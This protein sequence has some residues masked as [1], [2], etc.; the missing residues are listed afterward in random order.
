MARKQVDENSSFFQHT[1]T[2]CSVPGPVTFGDPT[3]NMT[4]HQLCHFG[5]KSLEKGENELTGVR[6]GVM[7]ALGNCRELKGELPGV[8][9]GGCPGRLPGKSG[10]GGQ[11]LLEELAK[12]EMG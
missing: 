6:L 3:L 1:F 12:R 7:S 9:V 5:L 8:R 4:R 11:E 2:E 10:I